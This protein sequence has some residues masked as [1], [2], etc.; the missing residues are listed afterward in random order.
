VVAEVLADFRSWLAE[1]ATPP[2][3]AGGEGEAD[4]AGR[5]ARPTRVDLHTLVGQ[6][7][8]LRHEVNL[9]TRATRAQQEQAGEALKLLAEAFEELQQARD[10]ARQAE[11]Q[12][13]DQ[14]EEELLRPLLKT[15]IDLYD[16]LSV[17]GREVR[18]GGES[19]LPVLEELLELAESCEEAPAARR[20]WW[21]L[22]RSEP[23][24]PH[25]AEAIHERGERLRQML[26]ALAAGYAM[27]LERLERTLEQHGLE[28]IPTEGEPFDP[29]QMEVV[30]AVA[31]SGRPSGEVVEEVRRGYLWRGRVFRYAQV[32][33][34]KNEEGI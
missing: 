22:G 3:E 13:R 4:D 17:S 2:A 21:S 11:Q 23:E 26:T 15:L 34:A 8:A 27:S 14:R 5:D 20:S 25:K 24:D 19:A 33:V 7:V 30:E 28:L 31:D 6:F 32:R 29:E 10:R 18:R 12:D 1:F 9:Q 16:V